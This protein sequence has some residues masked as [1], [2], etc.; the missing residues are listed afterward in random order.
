MGWEKFLYQGRPG[1]EPQRSEHTPGDPSRMSRRDFI[2][3]GIAFA[4]AGTTL[5]KLV[6]YF[7]SHDP[8]LSQTAARTE[9][10]KTRDRY[11]YLGTDHEEEISSI[12]D[13]INFYKEGPIRFSMDSV[14]AIKDLYKKRF[15]AEK[16]GR[17]KSFKQAYCEMGR[18]KYYLEEI[19][20]QE[21]VPVQFIYLA[22]PESRFEFRASS[23]KAAQGPYQ[24]IPKTGRSYGLTINNVIDERN[25]PLKSAR[26]CARLLKDLYKASGDWNLS[27]AGYNGGFIWEYLKQS[28]QENIKPSYA[29][30][31]LFL[32]TKINRVRN[33]IMD[34]NKF[35]RYELTSQDFVSGDP[36]KS[37]GKKTGIDHRFLAKVNN[38][39]PGMKLQPGQKIR[40]PTSNDWNEKTFHDRIR[41]FIENLQYPALFMA[42]TELIQE[43]K[44]GAQKEPLKLTGIKIGKKIE[45]VKVGEKKKGKKKSHV[46]KK[47]VR[48]E[49]LY[50]ISKRTGINL[51]RLMEANPSIKNV[52]ASLSGVEFIHTY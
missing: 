16:G 23:P 39:K 7:T 42:T 5:F 17:M 45:Q 44:A 20:R 29:D 33:E 6:D 32:T 19:F 30:F 36:L 51:T 8:Q 14:I 26:A 11:Q 37:V 38:L 12:L 24:F 41:G 10:K 35:Y 46:V 1:N 28:K 27:L 47:V 25:D 22:I 21:G 15:L 52:H 49:S 3:G 2:K 50:D 43:G 48:D 4:A 31:C 9:Q 13:V 40:V 18:W 34:N